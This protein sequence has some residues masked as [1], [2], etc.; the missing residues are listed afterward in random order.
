MCRKKT[1]W[2]GGKRI[3]I[4]EISKRKGHQN[5]VTVIGAIEA[6]KLIEVIDS[7]TQE[8]IIATWQQQTLAVR[9]KV[10]EVSVDMWGG[11]PKVIEQVFPNAVIVIDQ[12]HVIK[13][14]NEELNKIR[15]Q[16]QIFD[17]GSK[18]L[19]LKNGRDLTP[20]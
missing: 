1:G 2:S 17:R 13:A 20:E 15:R 12:F 14:V 6:G 18:F 16:V 9:A 8:D 4:D 7:Q 11:R 10:E 5:C 3:S 19:L